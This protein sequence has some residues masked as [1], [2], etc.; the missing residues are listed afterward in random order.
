MVGLFLLVLVLERND[1]VNNRIFPLLFDIL[2]V[3]I[4]EQYLKGSPVYPGSHVQE[5]LWFGTEQDA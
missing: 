4:L 2:H 3:V 1:K 5:G